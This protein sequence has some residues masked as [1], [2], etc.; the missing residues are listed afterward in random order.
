MFRRVS[1]SLFRFCRSVYAGIYS[2]VE[3]VPSVRSG[4]TKVSISFIVPRL[5]NGFLRVLE[6]SKTVSLTVSVV[7]LYQDVQRAGFI[8]ESA[9]AL[10][11][12]FWW[13][14]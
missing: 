1:I 5:P 10:E 13:G 6:T 12:F 7:A 14:L 9:G 3:I 4:S 11:T 8:A 2:I